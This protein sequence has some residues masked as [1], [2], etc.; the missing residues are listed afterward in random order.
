MF[1]SE[2]ALPGRRLNVL[3][4]SAWTRTVA[5]ILVALGVAMAFAGC[6]PVQ[7][8]NP[9]FESKD[10][11]FEPHLVGEWREAMG[12]VNF[13][14]SIARAGEESN[15]YAVRYAIHNDSPSSGH[16]EEAE[17]TFQGHLFKMDG[18]PYLDLLSENFRAKPN[19]G[20]V[21]LIVDSGLFA[22]PMHTVYRVWFNGDQLR[23]AY[24][25]D[26]RVK[27]FVHKRDLK[28]A[29]K[30]P[31]SFFLLATTQELQSQL[32]AWAE[33]KKLLEPGL[34]FAPQKRIQ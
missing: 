23:L 14:L 17:I 26:V 32:L 8:V 4:M 5:Q 25:D 24:L 34:E 18:V 27:G 33:E 16:A 10:V 15:Q 11:I 7:S 22:A 21:K 9:F 29:S 28:V 2:K 31:D 3:L 13:T 12:D 30:T 6:E 1:M 20:I 19:G